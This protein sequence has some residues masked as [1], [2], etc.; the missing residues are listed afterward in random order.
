VELIRE[1][2]AKLSQLTKEHVITACKDVENNIFDVLTIITIMT[3][4]GLTD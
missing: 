1:I 4:Y 3:P 2:T